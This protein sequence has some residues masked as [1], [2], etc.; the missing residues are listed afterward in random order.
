ML[1][2]QLTPLSMNRPWRNQGILMAIFLLCCCLAVSED[3]GL[4][5]PVKFWPW[6]FAVL[7]PYKLMFCRV[8]K[9][10]TTGLNHI[11]AALVPPP[12]P[13]NQEW[14]VHQA[15]DYGL[16][17]WNLTHILRDPSWYKVV[18]YREPLERFLSAYRSKCEGYDRDRTCDRV[19]H[20]QVPTFGGAIRRIVLREDF[21]GDSHFAPQAE[22][23]NLRKTLP[24]FTE[25]FILDP[26]TSHEKMRAVFQHAHV[27]L[28]E[29]M[30]GLLNT[31]FAP[32]GSEGDPQHNTHS[33]E[34]EALLKYYNHDCY[35]R[36]MVDH[37][38]EDYA[39]FNIPIPEWALGALSR[40]TSEECMEIIKSH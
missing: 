17:A 1:T 23:C 12:Y 18:M 11:I 3:N 10:G 40:V 29:A 36:L 25:K 6:D 34:V 2:A 38:E 37:Y 27:E 33:S 26:A 13:E 24:Y 16:D 35:I 7:P 5:I 19:F 22:T 14:T 4:L 28:N 9:A 32:A 21:S 39:L 20:H 15:T 31:Y 8:H 30:N